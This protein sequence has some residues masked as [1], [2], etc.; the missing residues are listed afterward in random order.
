MLY[1]CSSVDK[2]YQM[3]NR[4]NALLHAAY[5]TII[6]AFAATLSVNSTNYNHSVQQLI[7]LCRH[8]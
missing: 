7:L 4:D 6:S 5:I 2:Y 3:D 1:S 8:F